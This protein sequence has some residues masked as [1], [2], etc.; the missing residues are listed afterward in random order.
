MGYM[1]TKDRVNKKPSEQEIDRM[2][3]AQANDDSAW[4]EPVHVS[5]TEPT[6]L[7]IPADLAARA[8]FLAHLHHAQNVDRWLTR[9]IQERIE[10]EEAAFVG[11]KQD[12][13]AKNG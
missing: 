6:S 1:S 3:A 2:V 9:I 4:D 5:R 12:L 7:S 11:V 13:A 8:A 10:M